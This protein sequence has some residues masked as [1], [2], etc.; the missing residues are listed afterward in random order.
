MFDDALLQA[1]TRAGDAVPMVDEIRGLTMRGGKRL[2]PA[3]L[4]AAIECTSSWDTLRGPAADVGAA[5]ELLQ[6]YLLIHDDWM[7][8]DTVRRGGP[9]VHVALSKAY[10]GTHRGAATAI[11]AGDLA[12][13]L[14]QDLV[15]HA[16]LPFERLRTV[17]SAYVLMQREVVLGQT[18]DVLD[19]QDIDAIHDLKT[20]SYTVRGP[21]ALGHGIAGGSVATWTA[22]ESFARPIGIAFQLRDDVIGTFGDEAETGKSSAT[23]LRAGK[24]TAPV[25]FALERLDAAGQQELSALLGHDDDAKVTRAR[26]IIEDIGARAAVE[27]RIVA[28]RERA[29]AALDSGALRAEGAKLLAALAHVMTDRR[30]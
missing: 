26:A 13:S 1:R 22:L 19:A 6:T 17:L 29:L 20:G 14:A 3:M 12:S 15:A 7:D 25:R 21:L 4:V 30:K 10:G 16:D 23:D 2:R 28:L 5:I 18:L 11:L 24:R 8:G 9:T 27:E